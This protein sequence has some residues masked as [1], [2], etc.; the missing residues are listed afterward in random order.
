MITV[1]AGS[2]GGL[3]IRLKNDATGEEVSDLLTRD[4]A[5]T[6]IEQASA[7][8][9]CAPLDPHAKAVAS[10]EAWKARRAGHTCSDC[11]DSDLP[12][13][14]QIAERPYL[15]TGSMEMT[16]GICRDC[17]GLAEGMICAPCLAQRGA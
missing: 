14:C 8:L 1:L 10:F 2:N 4:A 9:R 11:D 12:C 7:T 6:L 16:L 17:G 3:I 15:S 13:T 5:E